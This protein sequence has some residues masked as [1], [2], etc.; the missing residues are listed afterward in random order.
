MY[1]GLADIAYLRVQG[2]YSQLETFGDEVPHA[3]EADCGQSQ[4]HHRED[5][6]HDQVRPEEHPV[7][8]VSN[9][10]PEKG[11]NCRILSINKYN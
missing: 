9:P 3:E 7:P 8:G 2:W 5:R 10:N 4:G 11:G 1:W 6:R